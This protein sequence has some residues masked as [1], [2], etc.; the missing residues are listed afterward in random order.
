VNVLRLDRTRLTHPRA[1]QLASF[2]HTV[3]SIGL[4]LAAGTPRTSTSEEC[5]NAIINVE[6]KKLERETLRSKEPV[7]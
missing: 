6:L 4:D 1:A 7:R 3:D 2:A 5:M